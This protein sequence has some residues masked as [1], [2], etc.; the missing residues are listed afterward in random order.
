M[1]AERD[2][3]H[4]AARL[5]GHLGRADEA[6]VRDLLALAPPDIFGALGSLVQ[7]IASIIAER[8]E[9]EARVAVISAVSIA[10]AC[11]A[12]LRGAAAGRG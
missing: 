11:A 2:L 5:A 9:P 3:H 10:I 6:L 4:I 12:V 7:A 1:A 8:T